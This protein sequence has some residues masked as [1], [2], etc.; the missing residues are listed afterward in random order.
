M[1]Q[2]FTVGSRSIV[3]TLTAWLVVLAAVTLATLAWGALKIGGFGLVAACAL[4]M[5]LAAAATGLLQ[6]YEWARR[7]FVGLAA[8]GAV[9]GLA[10]AFSG[11][12]IESDGAALAAAPALLVSALLAAL[13]RAL[14]SSRVRQEFA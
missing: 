2:T 7:V 1:P 8:A 9:A 10:V 6:R 14:T 11:P 12:W 5:A 13:V 3:V 4:A